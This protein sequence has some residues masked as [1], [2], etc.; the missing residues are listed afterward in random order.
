[1]APF[2]G[3]CDNQNVAVPLLTMYISQVVFSPNRIWAGAGVLIFQRSWASLRAPLLSSTRRNLMGTHSSITNWN[4]SEL[5]PPWSPVILVSK[6][7]E[8]RR[9]TR[10]WGIHAKQEVGSH[11]GQQCLGGAWCLHV[12]R[13]LKSTSRSLLSRTSLVHCA[14][15]SRSPLSYWLRFTWAFCTGSFTFRWQPMA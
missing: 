14:Y 7:S 4:L 15:S 10:N 11:C 6:A 8:L 5:I 9:L 2:I 13:K 1:M 3:K 12:H